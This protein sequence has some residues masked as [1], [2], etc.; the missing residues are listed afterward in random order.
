VRHHVQKICAF[1]KAMQAFAD[2]LES[3]G[4]H[5]RYLTLDDTAEFEDLPQL[6]ISLCQR[7][8]ACRL[9]FQRPDEYRLLLQVRN[10]GQVFAENGQ[11]QVR[12]EETDTEHFLLPYS[13]LSR[14]FKA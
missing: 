2:A 6:L 12:I 3:A 14:Y 5:V 1:F 4:H 8:Q 13:E 10:L 9:E 11:A 7:Y